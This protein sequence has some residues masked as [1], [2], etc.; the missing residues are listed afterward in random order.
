MNHSSRQ[1]RRHTRQTQNGEGTMS[2]RDLGIQPNDINR[3]ERSE[4]VL[5]FATIADGTDVAAMQG[6]LT[7]TKDAIAVLEAEDGPRGN[8]EQYAVATIGL[9]AKFFQRYP[10]L[11]ANNP[12]GLQTPPV[13][14]GEP[15]VADVFLHVTYTSEAKLA[16]FLRALWATRPV[17]AA[18]D[19]EHGYARMDR[20]EA[21]GQ[22]DGERNLTRQE[23]ISHTRIEVDDL[24]E[25]PHWLDGGSYAAYLKIEQNLDVWKGFGTTTHESIVGRREAD[26]SRL[27]LP[28]G[29]DPKTEGAFADPST[30]PI[31]SHVRKA[32]P[33]GPLHDQTLIFRRGAP[34]TEE[35]DGVL[36]VGLQFVSYQASLDDFD[37]VLNRWMLNTNFPNPNTGEDALVANSLMTFL[38]AGFFVI[39]PH[40]PRFPGAGYF[41]TAPEHGNHRI[42]RI[43]I[44]KTALDQNGS[45]TSAEVGDIEFQLIDPKTNTPIGEP[46]RANPAGRAVLTGARIGQDV[47]V[48][49]TPTDRFEAAPDVTVAVDQRNVIVPITNRLK[50]NTNP[51][52]G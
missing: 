36:H 29:T 27:D 22:L 5:V 39:P 33:R 4:A 11:A 42:G 40:D 26:G 34:Y 15:V 16:D 52:G 13:T 18:L 3:N 12:Y 30:P 10:E 35:I 25:E 24:P 49:E 38:R 48:R 2:D 47:I 19:V 6:W 46:V 7:A 17:L 31:A 43:H 14:R 21:F 20:R 50:P 44:R 45:P 1:L 28:A 51:Y 23:R 32:G 9:G 37:V 8:Q 41:D